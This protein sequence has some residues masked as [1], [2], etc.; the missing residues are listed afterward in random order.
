MKSGNFECTKCPDVP[1]LAF[2]GFIILFVVI[3]VLLVKSVIA[4]ASKD[5]K[6][7]SALFRV[8]MNHLQMLALLSGLELSWDSDVSSPLITSRCLNS[9]ESCHL[10]HKQQVHSFLSNA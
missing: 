5:T 4:N 2:F 7:Y 9:M 8:L 1:A 6:N 10:S 3:I